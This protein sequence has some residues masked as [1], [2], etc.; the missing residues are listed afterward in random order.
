ML[1]IRNCESE[2]LQVGFVIFVV[3]NNSFM[4]VSN[5]TQDGSGRQLNHSQIPQ[6]NNLYYEMNNYPGEMGGS[7]VKQYM[8]S[9]GKQFGAGDFRVTNGRG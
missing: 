9:S 2:R 6:S 5:T 8:A 1:A 3:W 7:Q 4:Q